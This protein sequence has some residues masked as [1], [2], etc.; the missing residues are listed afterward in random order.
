MPSRFELNEPALASL[1]SSGGMVW[2]HVAGLVTR[3]TALAKLYAPVRTGKL[4]ASIIG[5]TAKSGPLAIE[6][7]VGSTSDYAAYV[8]EGTR[9]HTIRPANGKAFMVIM[10]N[11]RRVYTNAVHHPGTKPN[12][13]LRRAMEEVLATHI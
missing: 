8:H 6:G 9:P 2:V 1:F 13:F 12:P 11:G 5:A 7:L 4:R 3:V 10:I